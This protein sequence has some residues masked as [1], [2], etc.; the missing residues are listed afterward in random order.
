MRSFSK[1]Q[2]AT[3]YYEKIIFIYFIIS[4]IF[5]NNFI[6]HCATIKTYLLYKE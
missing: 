5:Y 6:Y 4:I 1:K 3:I 2:L